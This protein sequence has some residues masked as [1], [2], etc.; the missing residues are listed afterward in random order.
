[1]SYDRVWRGLHWLMALAIVV[2]LALIEIKGELPKGPIKSLMVD[3]HK[4]LGVAVFILVWWRLVWRWKHR[5]PPITPALSR[6]MAGVSHVAHVLLYA[7]MIVIPALGVLFKQARG[8]SVN[9]IGWTLPAILND[10]SALQYA[11]TLKN[12]HE[13]LGTALIWLIVLH[14][15][16]VLYHHW[17]RRDDTLRRMLGR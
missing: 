15:V 14:A 6:S 12:L 13:N 7:A 16:A 5:I 1:M 9:F 4:Q 3:V 2:L 17:L 11:K 10:G 8:D